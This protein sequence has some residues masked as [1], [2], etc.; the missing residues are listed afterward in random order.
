M[1]KTALKLL[2]KIFH[3]LPDGLKLLIRSYKKQEPELYELGWLVEQS[4]I[5]VD[6]GANK[7]PYT[8]ALR[9]L[10]RE[11]G[12]VVAVEPIAELAN[13]LRRTFSQLSLP[14]IL[15]QCCLSSKNGDGDL[16]IPIGESG[17]L[18]TVLANLRKPNSS[19]M[20]SRRVKLKSLDDILK[21]RK[22]RVS[23]IKCDV[24]GHKIEVFRGALAIL[25]AD[26]PNLL[27]EIEKQ[28]IDQPIEEHFA[29]FLEQN[30]KGYFL[31]ENSNLKNL[32]DFNLDL[33]QPKIL[34]N[35]PL[36]RKYV[37]NFIFL[38]NEVPNIRLPRNKK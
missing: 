7:G 3:C 31:D 19:N 22:L 37:H 8:Y 6:I 35:S 17:E 32:D 21:Q 1:T 4:S 27:V 14:V 13:Y 18:L 11:K 24:E 5:A 15:E 28:H 12:H 9:K 2:L 26:R 10:V 33:Y 29:F 34:N 30:Y 36:P 25:K 23:F 16:Y 20:E 38:P